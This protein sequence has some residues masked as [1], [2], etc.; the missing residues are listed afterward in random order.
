MI[1]SL[2][3][4]VFVEIFDFYRLDEVITSSYFPWKWHTLARVCKTWRNIIFSSSRRLNLELFCT[5]GTPV[6]KNLDHFPA[7]PIVIRL[8]V[9]TKESDEDNIIAALEHP[10]RVRDIQLNVSCSLLEKMA[11]VMQEP[12]PVLTDLFLERGIFEDER[13][14]VLPDAFLGGCTPR[15]QRIRL[16]RIPFPAAPVFLSSA[17]DLVDVDLRDIPNTGYISPVEMV[18]SLATLPRLERLI[19]QFQPRASY[20]DQIRVPPITRTALPSLTTFF[21]NGFFKYFEYFVAQ[22]DAPQ[23]RRLEITYFN[24]DD[25][26]GF[27]IPQLSEFIDHSETLSRFGYAELD[28]WPV[29]VVISFHESALLSFGYFNLSVPDVGIS[30]VLSQIPGMLSNVDRLYITSRYFEYEHLSDE[31]QWLE[32]LLPF[33]A[34]KALSVQYK[35]ASHVALALESVTEDWAAEILP[36][37]ELLCLEDQPATS[38]EEFFAARQDVGRP[39]TFFVGTER[40]FRARL[41]PD[42]TE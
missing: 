4:N 32:F 22:M 11:T 35:L 18:A 16:I 30:Q 1:S 29:T 9:R 25:G 14:P 7:F 3:D 19:V 21:F 6:R 41:E 33:T 24:E 17:C 37:L 12:F 26:G 34:V 27:Q 36:A 42:V 15:L 38:V 39:V 2:P 20:V 28:F 8:P 23:L 40:E 31:I 10:D 5:Y 13:T